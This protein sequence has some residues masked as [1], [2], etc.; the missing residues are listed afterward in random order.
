M[1]EA[2][3]TGK[4][5]KRRSKRKGADAVI[6]FPVFVLV[7]AVVC[8]VLGATRR[9]QTVGPGLY[10]FAGVLACSA[11]VT[12]AVYV[13]RATAG[14][15]QR[16]NVIVAALLI[17]VPAFCCSS[18]VFCFVFNGLL[19]F[20]SPWPYSTTVYDKWERVY[21]SGGRRHV[22][23]RIAVNSWREHGNMVVLKTTRRVY[24]SIDPGTTEV[25]ITVKPGLLG[26][27]WVQRIRA[28]PSV[29]VNDAASGPVG[30]GE[31]ADGK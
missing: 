6:Q 25:E 21:R 13:W 14:Q 26:F 5:R 29:A 27:E 16:R 15:A 18:Y 22:K 10:W 12:F 7:A 24:E 11:L 3:R 20:R 28:L 8:H 1:V 30:G 4:R 17:G 2:K 31:C 23:H 19:D 9:F